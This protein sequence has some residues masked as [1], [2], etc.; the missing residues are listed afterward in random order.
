MIYVGV[1]IERQHKNH[2]KLR[3]KIKKYADGTDLDGVI[4][5]CSQH[6]ISQPISLIYTSKLLDRAHRINHYGRNFLL[7]V[8]DKSTVQD[9]DIVMQNSDFKS[10][11]LKNWIHIL[12]HSPMD[13]R[14][15]SPFTERR[16][17]GYQVH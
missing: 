6:R 8:G 12:C 11:S 14:E 7:F 16:S 2:E 1:E 3:L 13:S 9:G 10:V 15:E 4:Y 5:V 17:G